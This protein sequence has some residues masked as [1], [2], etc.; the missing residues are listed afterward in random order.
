MRTLTVLLFAMGCGGSS[1]GDASDTV[2]ASDGGTT[3][4]SADADVSGSS[5]STGGDTTGA[6]GNTDAT[7]EENPRT[8]DILELTGD[9]SEGE[10]LFAVECSNNCHLL[11]GTG[12][13]NGGIGKDLTIW[14][15][16]NDDTKLV[17]AILDGRPPYMARYENYLSDQQVADIVA[18]VRMAFDPNA[19]SG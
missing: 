2:A 5:G 12:A 14:L 17:G 1:S 4:D 11:D 7:P 3:G 9:A 16:N 15:G 6:N 18:Y 19:S 13:T 8:A 10:I